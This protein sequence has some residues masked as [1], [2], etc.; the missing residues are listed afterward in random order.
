[1]KKFICALLIAIVVAAISLGG[2][3]LGGKNGR[4]G[5]DLNI[6]DIYE[7]TNAA[8]EE[9]GLEQLKFLEFLQEYLNYEFEYSEEE[10]L[11]AVVN[12]SLLSSVAIVTGF[13]HG[14]GWAAS[15]EYHA[16]AGVIVEVD[17]PAGNAYVLTNAHIV[18]DSSAKPT[19][20][21]S[22]SLYLYGNDDIYSSPSIDDAE[23]V[24]YSIS[25]DLALL[26]VTGSNIIKSS[27]A[28]AAVFAESEEVYAG[29]RVYTVGNPEGA[30][31]SVT[32]GIISRDSEFVSID[33][34]EGTGAENLYRVMRTDTG[35][36]GGNSGG[37]LFDSSGR[38][39]GLINSKDPEPENENM[40]FA[41][42][43]SYVKRLWK[44]MRDGYT[45]SNGSYGVRCAVFS[46]QYIYTSTAYF[47]SELSVTVIRDSV[48]AATPLGGFSIGDQIKYIKILNAQGQ[49]VDE[50]EVT[51]FYNV[52]DVLL[53]AREGYKIVYT[54]ERNGEL[55]EITADPVFR[56][57]V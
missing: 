39:V 10:S 1:M 51:R 36:N 54:V 55:Q 30:G 50:V 31:I 26:K 37:A 33:F 7:A 40:G 34:A 2:C 18:Y 44:L 23:I 43:G 8:R 41:L 4:D 56:N 22:I 46:A 49:V 53:S 16:G 3:T 47:D 20:A 9:Q 15:T 57:F 35:V 12:R 45:S 27:D 11:R 42:C 13:R 6:Y 5:R 17:K 48:M 24:S 32:S 28:R 21:T 52:D 14:S 25:Y 29:E 19:Q 38:I